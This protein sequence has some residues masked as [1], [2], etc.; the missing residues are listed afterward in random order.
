MEGNSLF[1]ARFARL[2]III[3]LCIIVYVVEVK[4]RLLQ[5]EQYAWP[6]ILNRMSADSEKSPVMPCT[7]KI[8]DFAEKLE[9]Q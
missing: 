6:K 2:F 8:P 7:F 1:E 3:L 4:G 9:K 5:A